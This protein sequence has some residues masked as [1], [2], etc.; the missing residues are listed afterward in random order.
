MAVILKRMSLTSKA[1]GDRL[2]TDV[3]VT[4]SGSFVSVGTV[5]SVLMCCRVLCRYFARVWY[6][7]RCGHCTW[8]WYINHSPL[9]DFFILPLSLH[10][11]LY[12]SVDKIKQTTPHF[13]TV[14]RM[15][16]LNKLSDLV[17]G[18][19]AQA[20]Y[21][22]ILS[23]GLCSRLENFDHLR[24]KDDGSAV[25]VTNPAT[26]EFQVCYIAYVCMTSSLMMMLCRL[27][28]RRCCQAC[29]RQCITTNRRQNRCVCSKCRMWCCW[30]T[31]RTSA[32]KTRNTG[33]LF[34]VVEPTP[35]H[36][37]VSITGVVCAR[38]IV[39]ARALALNSCMVCWIDWCKCSTCCPQTRRKH[40]KPR[41]K[42]PRNEWVVKCWTA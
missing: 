14:G 20:G 26:I 30:A 40:V 24:R 22:E 3:P 1:D 32:P 5:M 28:A 7:G 18:E 38:C 25:S 12:S 35:T 33:T 42:R 39:R 4:R 16:P 17:R 15:Q 31:R 2:I 11:P 8:L 27:H 13:Y 36:H 9:L 19:L 10:S 34:M 29:W 37:H 41:T 23:L 6:Y 21:M